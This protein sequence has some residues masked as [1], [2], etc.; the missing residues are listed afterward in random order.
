MI[1]G[2]GISSPSGDAGIFILDV[3]SNGTQTLY[4]LST[5]VAGSNGIA[6]V[7][8]VD[9]DGDHVVDFVY[10]GDLL[11]NVWRF[12]LTGNSASSW[13]VTPG[14]IFKTPSGQPITTAI[15]PDFVTGP[16][17]STTQLMLFFGTGQKFP[18]TNSSTV[19][20]ETGTQ[21]FYGVWDWNMTGWDAHNSSQFAKLSSSTVGTL[22]SLGSPYTLTTSNLTKQTVAIDATTQDRFISSTSSVCWAGTSTCTG[23]STANKSFGWYLSLPGTNSAYS[24]TTYEQTVYNPMIVSTA[25][26]FNSILP[27]VDSPLMCTPDK[28]KGWTYALDVRTGGPIANF[29]DNPGTSGTN[30]LA[31]E[32]IGYEGD[33]SGTSSEVDTT[34][35]S[36]G[37]NYYLIFQSTTGGPGTPIKINPAANISSSRQ[38]WIQLR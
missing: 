19:S 10:A 6:Y 25:V 9:M 34:N 28:D 1:F 37:T 33:A 8:P 31:T 24:T 12:D 7:T 29:F 15:Q 2:N 30:N 26:V 14:P 27:A 4:Y 18:L 13:A 35:G 16:I 17:G 11:G 36:G 23:G 3:S 38:T 5:G 22:T 21:S 32:T 20:Y